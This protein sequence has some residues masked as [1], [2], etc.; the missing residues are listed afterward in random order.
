MFFFGLFSTHLPYIL[1]GV[2]YFVS[3]AFASLQAL[4]N[5]VVG[6]KQEA[7][8]HVIRVYTESLDYADVFFI[9]GA[10][11]S[12]T[13]V[14]EEEAWHPSIAEKDI[15]FI[16]YCNPLIS[17]FYSSELFVRPPPVLA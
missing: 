10:S 14:A 6:E 16:V 1:V 3:F 8:N 17:T 15:K 5:E 7:E 4:K 2:I 13:E 12:Y 9:D 11:Q